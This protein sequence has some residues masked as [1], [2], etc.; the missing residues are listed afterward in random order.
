MS[1]SE[2][3]DGGIKGIVGSKER[4]DKTRGFRTVEKHIH[5]KNGVKTRVCNSV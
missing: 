2:G 5:M 4:V 3:N 1:G